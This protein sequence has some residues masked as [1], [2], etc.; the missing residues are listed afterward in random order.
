M[1]TLTDMP[2]VNKMGF[3]PRFIGEEF[4]ILEAMGKSFW[5]SMTKLDI[6]VMKEN[7]ETSKFPCKWWKM[8]AKKLKTSQD[9][10]FRLR[11]LGKS[12]DPSGKSF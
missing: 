6:Y 2:G 8:D 11:E 10:F 5:I 3:E 4:L 12:F 7:N 9:I 1:T